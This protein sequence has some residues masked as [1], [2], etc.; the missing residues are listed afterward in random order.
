MLHPQYFLRQSLTEA[1]RPLTSMVFATYGIHSL[2]HC[3]LCYHVKVPI[4]CEH[5]LA[6]PIVSQSHVH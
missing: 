4:V 3:G 6:I 1:F 5:L 2:H